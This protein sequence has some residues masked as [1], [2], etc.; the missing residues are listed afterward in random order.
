MIVSHAADGGSNPLKTFS[1]GGYAIGCSV[2]SNASMTN[3]AG[4]AQNN[5][6]ALS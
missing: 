5:F 2:N 1:T 6:S 3:Q 4:E